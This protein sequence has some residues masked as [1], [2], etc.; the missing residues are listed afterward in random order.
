MRYPV[1]DV[2][3]LIRLLD[4]IH[5]DRTVLGSVGSTPTDR[6]LDAAKYRFITMIEGA[7]RVAHHLSTSEG[8]ASPDS[9]AAAF[10]VLSENNVI[11]QDLAGRLA[12]AAGFRNV[13][14]HQYA[15]VDDRMVVANLGRLEDFDRFVAQVGRWIDEPH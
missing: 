11:D 6:E 15:E 14:V 13:L 12:S 3:R 10:G 9:N 7:A 4:R 8:W 5:M 2:E 1:V